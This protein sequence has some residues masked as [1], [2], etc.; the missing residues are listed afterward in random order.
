M[1]S[2]ASH[3]SHEDEVAMQEVVGL[4]ESL[5]KTDGQRLLVAAPLLMLDELRLTNTKVTQTLP[6]YHTS[7]DNVIYSIPYDTRIVFNTQCS[8]LA[9]QV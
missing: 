5:V 2:C 3:V 1:L 4:V 9:L 8:I 7:V 6:V